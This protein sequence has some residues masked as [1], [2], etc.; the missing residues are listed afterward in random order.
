MDR[1][2]SRSDGSAVLRTYEGLCG[3]RHSEGEK[4]QDMCGD[5]FVNSAFPVFTS[6]TD[7]WDP[8]LDQST[9]RSRHSGNKGAGGH[10]C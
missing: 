9:P 2:E 7:G 4:K 5:T 8:T 6:P 3:V 1:D 10:V